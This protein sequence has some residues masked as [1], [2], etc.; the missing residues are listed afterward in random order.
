MKENRKYLLMVALLFLALAP[1]AARGCACGCG[2]FQV[3]TAYMLPQ[4]QGG[5]VTLDYDY[6]DQNQN[7]HGT[8][9]APP[10]DNDD[11]E[12]RTHF[13]TADLQY[14]VDRS[15]GIEVEVPYW[16]RYFR[17]T[18]AKTGNPIVAL[19]W[20][21][22]GDIRVQGIYTGFSPD[23]STGFTFGFKLPTGDYTHNNAYGDIDRDSEVGSG[24]T[25]VL[26]GF[27]HRQNLT[28][29]G[30]LTAFFQADADQPV[31][32]RENYTPGSEFDEALGIYYSGLRFHNVTISP[33]G[34]VIGS[35]RT[36][37]TGS[38]SAHPVAS[39]YQRLILSPAIEIDAHPVRVYGDVE[40][41]VYE[42]FRGDQLAA[43]VMFK[44]AVSIM[45]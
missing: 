3:G 35:E 14:M 40:F 45:F 19:D 36:I 29:D 15:W 43:S 32:A 22:M 44:A 13:I 1:R 28:S 10:A 25:D 42:N 9:A 38:E 37:D 27:F 6:Q 41:P 26:L 33:I 7:R 31:L 4:S 12:I 24:S 11:K 39:G 34:Q 30:K 18:S 2:V 17:T 21:A 8:A 16:N 20:W 5:M 23:M